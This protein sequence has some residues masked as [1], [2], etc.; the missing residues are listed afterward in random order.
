MKTDRLAGAIDLTDTDRQRYRLTD[1][2]R[3][4][5]RNSDRQTDWTESVNLDGSSCTQ[6][7]TAVSGSW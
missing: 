6:L 7:Y 3:H 1:G 4:G 5:R 2:Q